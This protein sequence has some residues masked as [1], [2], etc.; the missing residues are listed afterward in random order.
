MRGRAWARVFLA[1]NGWQAARA[2]RL[3]RSPFIRRPQ[4]SPRGSGSS[5]GERGGVERALPGIPNVDLA[6]VRS[7]RGSALGRRRPLSPFL[8]GARVVRWCLR[9]Q[10][11]R[12]RMVSGGAV[13]WKAPC[14]RMCACTFGRH[15]RKNPVH[16]SPPALCAWVGGRPGCVS[17]NAAG[18]GPTLLPFLAPLARIVE[19]LPLPHGGG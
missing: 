12:D 4:P 11:A 14:L 5:E 1:I 15:H 19:H 18:G 8:S 3:H 6:Q 2:R 9:R 13:T 10:A 17:F 7:T 16:S